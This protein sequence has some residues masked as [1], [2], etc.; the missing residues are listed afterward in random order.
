MVFDGHRPGPWFEKLQQSFLFEMSGLAS[1]TGDTS[2]LVNFNR[3]PK[4]LAVS[5]RTW[6]RTKTAFARGQASLTSG[7]SFI[8]QML[9]VALNNEIPVWTNS[10]VRDIVIEDGKATGVVAR[11]DGKDVRV[12]ARRGVLISSGGFSHN[13]EMRK[14]CLDAAATT[15]KVLILE[16]GRHGRDDRARHEPGC[17]HRLD[18]RSGVEPVQGDQRR[19]GLRVRPPATCASDRQGDARR[20]PRHAQ[21][22][23]TWR[24]LISPHRKEG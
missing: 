17:C 4:A 7:W 23:D 16:P 21:G 18:G 12:L 1:Y 15:G 19:C 22:N 24:P 20:V 10:A 2:K 8:G 9:Y 13:S 11:R 3:S 5:A 14:R 6:A